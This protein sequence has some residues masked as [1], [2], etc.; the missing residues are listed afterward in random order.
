MG[1]AE[2]CWG[3]RT[4]RNFPRFG[5]D[6]AVVTSLVT[7]VTECGKDGQGPGGGA[8]L[9]RRRGGLPQPGL[10]GEPGGAC[11]LPGTSHPSVVMWLL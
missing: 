7:A 8:R 2:N 3:L 11:E 10:R 6:V 1:A 5:R 4:S 9:A